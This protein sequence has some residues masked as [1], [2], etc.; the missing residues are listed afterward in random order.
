[1]DIEHHADAF[2]NLKGILRDRKIESTKVCTS[3]LQNNP[4]SSDLPLY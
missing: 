2:I 4:S 3:P 1:M